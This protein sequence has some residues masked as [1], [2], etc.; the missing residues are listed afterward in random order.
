MY[1]CS[2][3]SSLFFFSPSPSFLLLIGRGSHTVDR[4]NE[5]GA[6]RIGKE[7]FASF[8][9]PMHDSGRKGERQGCGE[10]ENRGA[11]KSGRKCG[12]SPW[13]SAITLSVREIAADYKGTFSPSPPPFPSISLCFPQ[14][15]EDGPIIARIYA[16]EDKS[17]EN[18]FYTSLH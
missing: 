2:I 17:R 4:A 9:R 15:R 5:G 11:R 6:A 3:I 10:R 7:I 14:R 18:I 1:L 13:S 12:K 8:F 16:Y